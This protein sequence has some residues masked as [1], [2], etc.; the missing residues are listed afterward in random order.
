MTYKTSLLCL[1][2]AISPATVLSIPMPEVSPILLIY[3]P[4]QQQ[5]NLT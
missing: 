4:K 2:L 3:W 1:F 5:P